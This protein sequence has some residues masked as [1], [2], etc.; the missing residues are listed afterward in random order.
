MSFPLY[1]DRNLLPNLISNDNEII[2]SLSLLCPRIVTGVTLTKQNGIIHL[3][4]AERT[5]LPYGQVE[6]TSDH[7]FYEPWKSSYEFFNIDDANVEENLDYFT[8][9]YE[10]RSINLDDVTVPKGSLVTGVRF[11]VNDIGHITL[12]VRAT[13][14]DFITG[15]LK[16]LT[17]SVWISNPNSGK[18]E[19]TLHRPTNP[20]NHWNTLS[21]INNTPNAF[22]KFKPT[23]FWDDVMQLTVP[24][25]D[26][27]RVEPHTPV[28][29]SGCGIYYKTTET[30][31]GG[32]IAPKLIVYDFEPYI[33]DNNTTLGSNCAQ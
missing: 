32:F 27:Q 9:S 22:I 6:T 25:I 18:T 30:G 14:F 15:K 23:D 20:L 2:F 21:H 13:P 10:N 26:T 31:S 8:L 3:A 17:N 12:N 29:L 16:D 5:M 19:I 11:Q 24:F 28:A 1:S 33:L 7:T 4:I